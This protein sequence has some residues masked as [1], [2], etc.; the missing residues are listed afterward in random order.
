MSESPAKA[1]QKAQIILLHGI[2]R[3][4]TDMLP[5]CMFL[6]NRGYKTL[7]ILY[8]SRKK[9]LE[10]LTELVHEKV[11]NWS[12]YNEDEPLHFVTHSM[13]GL[14][15]RYYI[16]RYNP[17]NLG[18]V[19]MLS[20]PNSGS[21]FADKL[22]ETKLTTG[23]YDKF[24]GPAGKQ[25]TTKYEHTANDINYPLGVIAGTKSI[26]PLA[27]WGLP[28]KDVGEHDGIVPV[29]RTKIEGMTDHITM[30]VNHTF[31]M[32]QPKVMEQVRFFL[33]NDR[34]FKTTSEE[35]VVLLHGIANP[36]LVMEPIALH[37][38]QYG[39]DTLNIEYPSQSENVVRLTKY[40]H[41]GLVKNKARQYQKVHFVAFSLGGLV[42]RSYL[43]RN[44]PD[45]IGRVVMIGTPNQGSEAASA[46]KERWFYKKF[47]GPAGQEIDTETYHP[48]ANRP[49]DFELGIIAGT[50]NDMN[51]SEMLMRGEKLPTPNDGAVSVENTKIDGMKDHITVHQPHPLLVGD[52]TVKDH[53]ANFL[54]TGAFN[55]QTLKTEST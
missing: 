30:P 49:V 25:L 50:K 12:D 2:L 44:M 35:L 13:G 29:E 54:R 18:K 33:D 55:G 28:K 40:I 46:L 8:P 1:Q 21:E 47:F 37:L 32:F 23:L 16:D 38:K 27:L 34:F 48:Y 22:I 14:I 39:Y 19:V 43:A 26:N 36:A 45:N 5:L 11:Q 4:K 17:K 51:P 7:N 15:A 6:K 3:S 53:V 9:S 10:A 52:N 20:P 31:M 42:L 41:R 24:F